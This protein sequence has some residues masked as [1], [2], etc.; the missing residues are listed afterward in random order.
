MTN[1]FLVY[2]NSGRLR[3]ATRRANWQNYTKFLNK[4]NTLVDARQLPA[5]DWLSVGEKKAAFL[6]HNKETSKMLQ[7]MLKIAGIFLV[8]AVIILF[9]AWSGKYDLYYQ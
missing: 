4:K 3:W 1:K 5:T 8:I 7:Q 6:K 2:F 9:V